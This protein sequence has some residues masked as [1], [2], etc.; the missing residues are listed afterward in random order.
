MGCEDD[1]GARGF[2]KAPFMTGIL[3][4]LFIA[5]GPL[6][7]LYLY[8]AG[9]ASFWTGFLSNWKYLLTF[10]VAS[11]IGFFVMYEFTMSTVANGGLKIFIMMSG[12]NFTFFIFIQLLYDFIIWRVASC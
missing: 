9:T 3:S 4:G 10:V 12:V 8:T 11:L 2:Y 7:S 6:Q 5:C 1:A